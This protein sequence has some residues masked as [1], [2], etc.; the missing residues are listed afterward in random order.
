MRLDEAVN[1]FLD[2]IQVEL[3]RSPCTV[4]AYRKDLKYFCNYLGAINISASSPVAD[5]STLILRKYFVYVREQRNYSARTMA[6]NIATLKSFFNF[7][8]LEGI[9]N[10]NPA[11]RLHAPRVPETIPRYLT[12][13]EIE[14]IFNTVDYSSE[15]GLRDFAI[16]KTLYYSGL[17]VSELVKLEVS[18]VRGFK[19]ILVQ[20]GKGGKL[21]FVPMHIKLQEVLQ[22]YLQR[23]LSTSKYLF[24]SMKGAESIS[25]QCVRLLVKAYAR[26]AGIEPERVTPHVFR[27]SFATYL[28]KNCN[29]DL[30]RISKLLG[31]SNLRATTIYTHT[32][33]DHLMD[34]IKKL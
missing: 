14:T 13:D 1:S 30:L 7:L 26:K 27:H 15:K 8:Q 5:I 2:Y 3:Q 10:S 31:H 11:E 33:S 32:T 24:Y 20:K 9:M 6:R 29:I 12:K 21:R 17:R 23:R 22:H 18:D 25:P 19:E 28:Y 16:L 4:S 34:A